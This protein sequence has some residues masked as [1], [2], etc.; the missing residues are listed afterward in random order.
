MAPNPLPFFARRGVT[1]YVRYVSDGSSSGQTYNWH[2]YS[3]SLGT[4]VFDDYPQFHVSLWPEWDWVETSSGV[5]D[6]GSQHQSDPTVGKM[7][8]AFE[9]AYAN[10]QLIV[11]RVPAGHWTPSFVYGT[12]GSL[13]PD[14]GFTVSGL[15][16]TPYAMPVTFHQNWRPQLTRLAN[17]IRSFLN[18]TLPDGSKYADHILG[19]PLDAASDQG[20]EWSTGPQNTAGNV[21][22]FD[23]AIDAYGSMAR[24][25]DDTRSFAYPT[26]PGQSKQTWKQLYYSEQW[27]WQL[28][29]YLALFPDVPLVVPLGQL[30]GDANA[31]ELNWTS[32]SGKNIFANR[33]VI[34]LR[35]NYRPTGTNNTP[36]TWQ[37]YGVAASPALTVTDAQALHNILSVGGRT[38]FQ[39][40]DTST[41]PQP[42]TGVGGSMDWA[43]TNDLTPN[44]ADLTFYEAGQ[45]H[46]QNTGARNALARLHTSM[47][48]R[49]ARRVVLKT[50][51]HKLRILTP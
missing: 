29:K 28:R 45:A 44:W 49:A 33:H 42:D 24:A 35:T 9:R 22:V 16:V 14:F 3:A 46:M 18:T 39:N 26:T 30:F 4:T 11:L 51:D 34:G 38:A 31:T 37:G 48:R 40:A 5:F 8:Y 17:A 19:M 47:Q 7:H 12:T 43:V 23:A 6:W 15:G 27:E 41:W 21:A 20:S 10:N 25:A 36:A 50:T 2:G 13:V 32:R 1:Y